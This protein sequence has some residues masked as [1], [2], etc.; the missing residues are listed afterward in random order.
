[1]YNLQYWASIFPMLS[2]TFVLLSLKWPPT[3]IFCFWNVM[4][5]LWEFLWCKYFFVGFNFSGYLHAF[6]IANTFLIF[7]FVVV[8]IS[9]NSSGCTYRVSPKLELSMSSWWA[10]SFIGLFTFYLV[11][12]FSVMTFCFCAA[13]WLFLRNSF[14]WLSIF[15]KSY[16]NLSLQDK[17]V[18]HYT[19]L[20]VNW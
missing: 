4:K 13:F 18:T 8:E 15:A 14:F 12:T 17:V 19:W 9:L 2:Q 20:C 10:I 5:Y 11:F 7:F 16:M 6:F 3:L 1:M